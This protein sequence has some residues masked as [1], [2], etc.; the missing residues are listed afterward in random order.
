MFQVQHCLPLV[1]QSWLIKQFIHIQFDDSYFEEKFI[2][3]PDISIIFHFKTIPLITADKSILLE[4]FFATPIISKSLSIRLH[5][6]L[7][8]FIVSCKPS[9]FSRI[10]H[11]DL[12]SV[13]QT[14]PLPRN[15]FYPLWEQLSELKTNHER[16]ILF[17]QFIEAYHRHDYV[18]DTID[19]LYDKITVDGLTKLLKDIKYDCPACQRTLERN[20]IKRTGVTPKTLMRIMRIDHLL[21]K[22]D[23]DKS[24][25]YQ[26]LVFN[27]RYFDQAHFIND[28]K[29]IVDETPSFFFRRDINVTKMI[30]GRIEG[31][32]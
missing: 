27:G 15:L 23:K 1:N 13:Q 7:D 5:G 21:A 24:I 6:N 14:I 16:I 11:L 18:P 3:R 4:P 2:P 28:F 22:I 31:H 19:L 10:F 9:V 26:E 30:S 12:S 29:S 8:S 20:F 17:T 25:E 32:L